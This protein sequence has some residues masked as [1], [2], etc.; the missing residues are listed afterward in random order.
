ML[1]KHIHMAA[2]CKNSHALRYDPEWILDCILLRIRSPAYYSF[3]RENGFM[4]LPCMTTLQNY[5]SGMNAQFGFDAGLFI[6]LKQKLENIPEIERMGILMWDEI[7]I[8]KHI[9]INKTTGMIIGM[10]DFGD[11]MPP[12]KQL[13]EYA[14]HALVFL[15]Q[16]HCG[17]WV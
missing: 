14:D 12:D 1:I 11:L 13:N 2:K 15:F 10:T 7:T 9:E 8:Q 3:L 5:I 4:P 6:Q 16:P 17:G